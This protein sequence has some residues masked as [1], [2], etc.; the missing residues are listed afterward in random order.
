[1][2]AVQWAMRRAGIPVTVAEES[3]TLVLYL[4]QPAYETQARELLADLQ[5]NPPELDQV[6]PP[7]HG[8]GLAQILARQAGVVTFLVFLT[9]MLVT[10]FQWVLAQEATLNVLLI[11]P[12]GEQQ[13]T[14][15]QPWRLLTPMLLH[16]SAT[17]LVFNLFWW[18]YLG[19]R[20]EL[21]YGSRALVA[22]TLVSALASNL[23]QYVTSGPLFG[24]LSGVVYALLG[25][26][27]LESW[28]RRSS[29]ALPPALYLFMIGWLFLGYTGLLWTN[30]A[31]EAHLVG[32]LT[33]MALGAL[34]RQQALNKQP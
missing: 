4:I 26:C 1:M 19:G 17:H 33:G 15:S 24:G 30:V 21:K 7:N 22:I 28:N 8:P 23:A 11:A 10:L 25:F 2:A 12:L 14:L 6:Q 16:F 34:A 32:L 9:V 27:M 5:R 31:N 29:L 18:W 13:L 3:G 20:I